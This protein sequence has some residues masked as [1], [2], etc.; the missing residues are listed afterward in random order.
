MC[1]LARVLDEQARTLDERQRG[2]QASRVECRLGGAA[3]APAPRRF[4]LGEVGGALEGDRRG[5]VC[6]ARDRLRRG[7]LELARERLVGAVGHD[8]AMPGAAHGVAHRRRERLMGLAALAARRG[9]VDRRA[10]ERMAEGHAAVDPYEALALGVVEGRERQPQ[11]FRGALDRGEVAALVGSR[12]Q[13]HAA[14][15]V[16]QVGHAGAER[17][18]DRAAH[19]RG[20]DDRLDPAE[21]CVAEARGQ[22]EQRERVAVGGLQEA[23]DDVGRHRAIQSGTE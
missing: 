23:V 8:R 4:V 22:L 6:R 18:L 3:Q 1:R 19:R 21:L 11:P 7:A 16:G 15:G 10:H 9:A 14:R 2:V 12:Q 20:A 5:G 17:G 13:Q